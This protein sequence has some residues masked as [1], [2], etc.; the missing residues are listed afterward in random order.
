MSVGRTSREINFLFSIIS[1]LSI[2]FLSVF[3]NTHHQ[4]RAR[5]TPFTPPSI[6]LAE[7]F[8]I[9][10][11]FKGGIHKNNKYKRQFLFS[12]GQRGGGPRKERGTESRMR[13]YSRLMMMVMVEKTTLEIVVE[14]RTPDAMLLLGYSSAVH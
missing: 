4:D 8:L 6:L 10:S 2:R 5:A 12:G 14:G 11:V 7:H 9:F 1:Q 3:F 13:M